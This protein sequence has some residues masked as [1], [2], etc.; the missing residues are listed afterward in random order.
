MAVEIL[1]HRFNIEKMAKIA[2][3]LQTYS[4]ESEAGNLKV[5]SLL[6]VILSMKN[7]LLVSLSF[8]LSTQAPLDA[9]QEQC[10]TTSATN[11]HGVLQLE[12]AQSILVQFS[13]GLTEVS[14]W[15]EETQNLVRQ[16]SLTPFSFDAFR[17][18]QDL[19]QVKGAF[20]S[21]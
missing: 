7:V 4:E 11:S 15:L 10:A 17:E 8:H 5:N 19:L 21:T 18:Q 9:L 1:Q 14:P 13:E 16:L 2:E 12:H 20:F 3:I 6:Y